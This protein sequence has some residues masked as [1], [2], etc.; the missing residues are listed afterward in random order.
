M[1]KILWCLLETDQGKLE[2]KWF[3]YF[4]RNISKMSNKIFKQSL[5]K[6]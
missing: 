3:A 1:K 4:E 6:I 5:S 2:W